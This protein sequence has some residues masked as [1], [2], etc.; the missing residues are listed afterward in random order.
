MFR[1]P[2]IRQ[3]FVS[4]ARYLLHHKPFWQSIEIARNGWNQEQSQYEIKDS[5]PPDPPFHP[6][7]VAYPSSLEH[8]MDDEKELPAQ[9]GERR[10]AL[11]SWRLM[12]EKLCVAWWPPENFPVW[13]P[14]GSLF[15]PATSI[16]SGCLLWK[17]EAI[18]PE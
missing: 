6:G 1:V 11:G 18:D 2:T 3:R 7:H 5:W 10:R 17:R 14:Q 16:V 4:R 15:H 8:D 12:I 9:Y 13:L